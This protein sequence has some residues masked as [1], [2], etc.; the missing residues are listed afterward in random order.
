M[1]PP[2]NPEWFTED[3]DDALRNLERLL[4]C[5]DVLLAG[6]RGYDAL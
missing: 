2:E 6:R 1:G 5:Q 4:K 3:I